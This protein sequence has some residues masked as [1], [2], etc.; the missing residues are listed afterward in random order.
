MKFSEFPRYTRA[1]FAVKYYCNL[2]ISFNLKDST[3]RPAPLWFA[4]SS[5]LQIL[6]MVFTCIVTMKISVLAIRLDIGLLFN[7]S[8][9]LLTFFM[10]FVVFSCSFSFVDFFFFWILCWRLSG[11]FQL[12]FLSLKDLW[13]L[14]FVIFCAL[15]D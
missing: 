6:L 5:S 10:L 7:L 14:S 9:L 1:T 3:T 8:Y 13:K 15:K 4:W 2:Q 12:Q 11:S